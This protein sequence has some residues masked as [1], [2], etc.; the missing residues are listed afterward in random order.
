MSGARLRGRQ[1]SHDHGHGCFA[2]GVELFFGES[3]AGNDVAFG[4]EPVALA[5]LEGGEVCLGAGA[6]G[7]AQLDVL[8][9]L[10]KLGV[11]GGDSAPV[12][13]QLQDLW[14]GGVPQVDGV[15]RGDGQFTVCGFAELQVVC[16]E[17]GAYA[18]GVDR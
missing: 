9:E 15:A 10:R 4:D 13:A 16:A 12:G 1:K 2:E 17:K 5:V 11:V 3:G 14:V 8:D 7:V 18:V 6:R